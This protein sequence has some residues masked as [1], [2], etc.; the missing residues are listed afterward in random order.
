MLVESQLK[1]HLGKSVGA[2]LVLYNGA[3]A[4]ILE[5]ESTGKSTQGP[6]MFVRR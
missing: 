1:C 3:L 4:K 2:H 5:Y 6:M